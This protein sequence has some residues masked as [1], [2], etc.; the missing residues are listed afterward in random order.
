MAARRASDIRRRRLEF[1]AS[2]NALQ[3][4][5]SDLERN[6]AA[7]PSQSWAQ[8]AEKARY[9]LALFATTTA[10]QNPLRQRLIAS[11]LEDFRT[12]SGGAEPPPPRR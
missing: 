12:L 9:L 2:R 10:A 6:L 3:G 11:V 1:D 7:S 4:R 8:A 5:A